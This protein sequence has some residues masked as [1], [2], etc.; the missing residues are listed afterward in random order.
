MSETVHT[1]YVGHKP[2]PTYLQAIHYAQERGAKE[3]RILARGRPIL[4]AIDVVSILQRNGGV[5][6]GIQIGSV[7]KPDYHGYVSTVEITV[8]MM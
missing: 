2:L 3:L 5:I 8:E 4:T 6:T 7:K 1:I